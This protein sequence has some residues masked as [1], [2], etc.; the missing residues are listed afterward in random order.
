[1]QANMHI[2]IATVQD[3]PAIDNIYNQAIKEQL[4]ADTVPLST[5]QRIKWLEEHDENTHPVFV[6]EWNNQVVGWL[7]FSKYRPGRE[8]LRQTAEISYY[9]HKDFRK[10]GIG[11]ELVTFAK[12]QAA[13]YGFKNLLALVL[14]YNAGSISLLEKCRFE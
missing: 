8:A 1:I 4:T 2:R 10:K 11:T 12:A 9:I 14:E 6:Y 13:N 3:L 7:S 5:L